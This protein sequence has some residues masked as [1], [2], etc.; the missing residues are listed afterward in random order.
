MTKYEGKMKKYERKMKKYEKKNEEIWRN[1]KEKCRNMKKKWR[2]WRIMKK[3]WRNMFRRTSKSSGQQERK[4]GGI[5]RRCGHNSWN[6]PHY[7]KGNRVSRQYLWR[8]TLK[9]MS[10]K[11]S[12]GNNFVNFSF[13]IR[14]PAPPPNQHLS[15][16]IP[17]NAFAPLGCHLRVLSQRAQKIRLPCWFLYSPFFYPEPIKIKKSSALH[18]QRWHLSPPMRRLHCFLCRPDWS[19]FWKTF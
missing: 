9:S 19:V 6:G 2:E 18:R 12:E 13:L 15:Q 16:Q 8:I 17:L 11:S 5:L 14:H 3:I 4:G 10:R 1:M 7:R